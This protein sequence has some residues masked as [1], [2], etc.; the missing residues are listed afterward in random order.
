MSTDLHLIQVP[1]TGRCK[2][3][4]TK[5]LNLINKTVHAA[6]GSHGILSQNHDQRTQA[7]ATS[8]SSATPQVTWVPEGVLL[9]IYRGTASFN[10]SPD[11]LHCPD[12]QLSPRTVLF[13]SSEQLC[14][15]S[16]VPE[17]QGRHTPHISLTK[18]T[19]ALTKRTGS[20]LPTEL[21]IKP[22]VRLPARKSMLKRTEFEPFSIHSQHFFDKT[23]MTC[24][25]CRAPREMPRCTGLAKA[26]PSPL[27]RG[28]GTSNPFRSP[29]Y[30][31]DGL[32]F[33]FT[34]PEEKHDQLG[35]TCT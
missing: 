4:K 14:R 20:Q 32:W 11:D 5:Q 12:L 30:E 18:A 31:F 9:D 34:E 27:P 13:P 33:S 16:S 1:N 25:S 10:Q 22:T 8:T 7:K 24:F 26:G 2:E 15:Y 29:L 35:P 6:R 19:K 17:M 28:S 3:T 21:N 23:Y